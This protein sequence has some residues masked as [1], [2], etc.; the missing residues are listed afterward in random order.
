MSLSSLNQPYTAAMLF[1]L[2]VERVSARAWRG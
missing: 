1:D 2:K